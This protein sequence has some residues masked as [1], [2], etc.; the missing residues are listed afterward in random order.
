VGI[1][2][3]VVRVDR[4]LLTEHDVNEYASVARF[5]RF[6]VE[7]HADGGVKPNHP[8]AELRNETL[9]RTL[10]KFKLSHYSAFNPLSARFE[11]AEWGSVR[12]PNESL[13]ETT[14]RALGSMPIQLRGYLQ[15]RTARAQNGW[16]LSSDSRGPP[17]FRR[18]SQ[19]EQW[20]QRMHS[21][22]S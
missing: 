6:P 14:A 13:A 15:T 9:R 2:R 20:S 17:G 18:D 11:L 5:R 22:P 4:D 16:G 3:S 7:R 19:T 21:G 1:G 12:G 8:L 10:A